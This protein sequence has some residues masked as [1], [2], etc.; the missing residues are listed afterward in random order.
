LTAFPFPSSFTVFPLF[1]KKAWRPDI[2]KITVSNSWCD[3]S[4]QV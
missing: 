2:S 1:R 4:S 3:Y